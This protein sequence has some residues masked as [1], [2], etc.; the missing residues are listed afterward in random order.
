MKITRECDYAI[1]IILMLGGL[2]AGSIADAGHISE[3]QCIPRQ[4]TLKILRKLLGK[5]YVRSVKGAHGGYAL[6]V[7]AEEISIYDVVAAIDGTVGINECFSCGYKCN[8]VESLDDC[9]VHSYLASVN[10]LIKAELDKI[11]FATLIKACSDI[12]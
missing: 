4:F 3:A 7:S 11:K 12:K 10:D 9:V 2:D 1:R 6:G 5:G 8:R